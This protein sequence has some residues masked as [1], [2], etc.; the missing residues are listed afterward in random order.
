M[1][2][3]TCPL[4]RQLENWESLKATFESYKLDG[5]Q[6]DFFG[7]DAPLEDTSLDLHHIHLASDQA[8]IARWSRLNVIHHRTTSKD[9]P[10]GDNWLIYGYNDLS[11]D[12]LLITIIGPDAHNRKEWASNINDINSFILDPW[13]LNQLGNVE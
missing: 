3:Y 11:D 12:Y 7:R 10:D 6:P 13:L 9:D 4:F 2:V 5:I 1:A 8:T